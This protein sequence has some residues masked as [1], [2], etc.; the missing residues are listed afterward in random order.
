MAI[1]STP[2]NFIV[3]QANGQVLCSWDISAGAT[4]YNVLRSTDNLTFVSVGAPTEIQY[5]DTT[6]TVNTQYYYTVEAVNVNG[7]SAQAVPQPI[8][9]TVAGVESLAS[10]RL[11]AQ[12][13]ADRVNSNFVT[14][15][16]WNKYINQ[17]ATELYDLLITVYEDYYAATPYVFVTDGTNSQY[18]LPA[19]QV[20]VNSVTAK[21][22]YKLLGVDCGLANND[23]AKITVHKYDFIERNRYVYPNVTS[24]FFGVFNM[25]YRV[26]GSNITF[27]PTP[28]AGQYITVHYIPRLV[29]MLKDTDTLDGISG[30]A[31]YVI[32]DAAIKALQKE[33]SDVSLL[34]AEKVALRKRI[35]E[36]ATNRDAGQPDVISRTRNYNS[37][38]GHG[39]GAGFDGSSG[40]Y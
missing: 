11:Q 1:P 12:Q 23:N 16:E 17:S 15:P 8:I 6:V 21:Q 39:G 19:G 35:E 24:T 7:S 37:R 30:W 40:G 25:R 32:V 9:A 20:D 3:Q 14:K 5:L 27:I 34:M 36:S 22:F 10:L 38:A 33:E 26:M 18:A 31:E 4:S 28:S 13:R 29:T 2:I